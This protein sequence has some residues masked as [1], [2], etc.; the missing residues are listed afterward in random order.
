MSN[1]KQRARIQE[2]LAHLS[3][4]PADWRK[5]DELSDEGKPWKHYLTIVT[6][7]IEKQREGRSG[8][9]AAMV[10]IRPWVRF[11][12]AYTPP[13]PPKEKKEAQAEE[14]LPS[15]QDGQEEQQ[16]QQEELM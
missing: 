1:D 2:I 15:S 11:V 16:Q 8:E 9:D 5:L 13:R 7:T 12:D 3:S 10:L 14:N 4:V 6:C